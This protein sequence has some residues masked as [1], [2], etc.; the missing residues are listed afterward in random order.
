MKKGGKN[1]LNRKKRHE[2]IVEQEEEDNYEN[3]EEYHLFLCLRISLDQEGITG[4]NLDN[5]ESVYE[6]E[7]DLKSQIWER[8]LE[9]LSEWIIFS[10]R[11]IDYEEK[12]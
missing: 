5:L 10:F 4:W 12:Y 7:Q 3:D 9:S 11:K 8:C 1:E 6:E 2:T